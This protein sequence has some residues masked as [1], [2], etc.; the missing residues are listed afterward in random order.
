MV[1]G[2]DR[3][4]VEMRQDDVKEGDGSCHHALPT[5]PASS[6]TLRSSMKPLSA[7][8]LI[9]SYPVLL[10]GRREGEGGGGGRAGHCMACLH[11]DVCPRLSLPAPTS[12][13]PAMGENQFI[14]PMSEQ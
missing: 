2:L 7:K 4:R 14:V 12:N 10:G 5:M 6:T 3:D 13:S 1:R 11:G 8:L 9:P